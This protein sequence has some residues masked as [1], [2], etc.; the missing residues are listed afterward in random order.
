LIKII[1]SVFGQSF[2]D[3]EVIIVC[4]GSTDDT[5][6]YFKS[7]GGERGWSGRSAVDRAPLNVGAKCANGVYLTFLDSDDLWFLWTL[8]GK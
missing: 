2:T 1:N 7:I 6:D 5:A 4:D 3:F 8:E